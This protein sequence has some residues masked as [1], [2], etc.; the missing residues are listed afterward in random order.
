MK[1]MEK[2]MF[3]LIIGLVLLSTLAL[4]QAGN[5]HGSGI[6]EGRTLVESNV[7]C[8]GLT[9]EQFESIGDYFM[10]QMHPGEAHEMMDEMMGGEGSEGLK[11]MHIQMAERLYCNEDDGGMT[12][13]M[14]SGGMMNMMG[15]GMMGN[16]MMGSSLWGGS[17]GFWSIIGML[18]W[19][20]LL[21]ALV[22]LI[23]WLYKGVTGNTADSALDILRSR[24]AKGELTKEQ[25]ESMK[26]E[27]G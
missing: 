26:R 9:D 16:N 14:G 25:Y 10:E 2:M 8:A 7:E 23:V 24:Y 5:S 3:G 27:L 6:A 11:Q 21:A 18:F 22:L 1:S 12:N 17:W 15:S 13:M 20:A 19:I 4:A